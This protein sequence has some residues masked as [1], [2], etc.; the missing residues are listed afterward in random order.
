MKIHK[1]TLLVV[2]SDDIGAEDIKE[3]IENQKYPNYCIS[4]SVVTIETEEVDWHD[5]HPLNMKGWQ[6]FFYR[7]FARNN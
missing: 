3:V 6:T 7:L 2:D 4:P 5:D 1:V